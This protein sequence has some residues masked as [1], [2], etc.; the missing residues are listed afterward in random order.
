MA[1]SMQEMLWGRRQA[2]GGAR[3][4]RATGANGRATG[5]N[6]RSTATPPRSAPRPA[7]QSPIIGVAKKGPKRHRIDMDKRTPAQAT[8]LQLLNV[9]HASALSPAGKQHFAQFE[10]HCRQ[11]LIT[12]PGDYGLQRAC[13]RCGLLYVPGLTCSIRVHFGR[14]RAARPPVGAGA[15]V[16]AASALIAPK[17]QSLAAL[18]QPLTA[19]KAQ[20][21][22]APGAPPGEA[23]RGATP[24]RPRSLVYTCLQCHHHQAIASLLTPAAPSATPHATPPFE[25]T[26]PKLAR[27]A[28]ARAKKRR[29]THSLASMLSS[30]REATPKSLDLMDFMNIH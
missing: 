27:P 23:T 2:R 24:S 30:K 26:W 18:D 14:K 9:A 29:A 3:D 28:A 22:R 7:R 12:L 8:A 1:G 5:R 4:G 15:A 6:G 19:S 20:S 25:A 21:L 13:Q 17:A 16:S 10:A 11:K